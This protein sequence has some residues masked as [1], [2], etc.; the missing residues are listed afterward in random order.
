MAMSPDKNIV[1]LKGQTIEVT[2]APLQEPVDLEYVKQKIIELSADKTY[3]ILVNLDY[4]QS[5]GRTPDSLKNSFFNDLP[6]RKY[7]V[8]GGS[9]AVGLSTKTLFNKVADPEK[10]KFFRH[11]EDARAWLE[12]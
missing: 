8:F 1:V 4:I 10:V 6:F 12:E 9:P 5:A 7:A 2:L 3:N 11:E